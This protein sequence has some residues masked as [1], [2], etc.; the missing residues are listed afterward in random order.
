MANTQS[1]EKRARQSTK[2]YARN[3]WYRG[4]ARTFTKRAR[5]YIAAGD[6]PEAEVAV[7]QAC[8]ALDRAAQK[9]AIHKNKAARSKS[10][11]MQ[12]LNQL[13]S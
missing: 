1:A 2:R 10:R 7:R 5:R 6:R 13:E 9:R 8:Q 4:R 12:A 3:R 11:L